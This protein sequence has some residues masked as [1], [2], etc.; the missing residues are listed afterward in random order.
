MKNSIKDSF[1]YQ[2]S[3]GSHQVK[4]LAQAFGEGCAGVGELEVGN[5]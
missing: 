1:L 3:T 2:H 4:T 5:H